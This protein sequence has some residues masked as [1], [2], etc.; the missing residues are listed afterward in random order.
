MKTV[1]NAVKQCET[2]LL[3]GPDSTDSTD[4]PILPNWGH[5]AAAMRERNQGRRAARLKRRTLGRRPS[6]LCVMFTPPQSYRVAARTINE[7]DRVIVTN[8][9][10][11]AD[12]EAHPAATG[13]SNLAKTRTSVWV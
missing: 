4:F 11:F 2:R 12:T 10:N 5:M 6:G 8:R 9:E 13:G 3:N 7:R 1:C